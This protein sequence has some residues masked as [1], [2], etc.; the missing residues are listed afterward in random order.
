MVPFGLDRNLLPVMGGIGT[1]GTKHG[2]PCVSPRFLCHVL[3][4]SLFLSRILGV[5][6]TGESWR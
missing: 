5:G 1:S 2:D 3:D 6:S 4:V